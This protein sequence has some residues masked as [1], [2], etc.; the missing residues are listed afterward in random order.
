MKLIVGLGNPGAKY[1]KNRHNLGFMVVDQF[2]TEESMSFKIDRDLMCE[3]S[4]GR[5]VVIIKPTTFMNQSGNSVKATADCF[6]VD[7]K[8][9][10]VVHDDLDLE[11]GKIRIAFDGSSA[12]H[13]G[14]ESVIKALATV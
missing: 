11:L 10:L 3:L 8:D 2:A 4:R 12:G 13:K 9:I 5:Q 1:S 14:L 6:K 7:N